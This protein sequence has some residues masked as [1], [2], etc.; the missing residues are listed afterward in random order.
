M[1]YILSLHDMKSRNRDFQGTRTYSDSDMKILVLHA[2]PCLPR[3][4]HQQRKQGPRVKTALRPPPWRKINFPPFFREKGRKIDFPPSDYLD[5]PQPPLKKI[6]PQNILGPHFFALHHDWHHNPTV[7]P[8]C[9]LLHCSAKL[10]PQHGQCQK[11]VFK[12]FKV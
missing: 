8:N 11:I 6:D 2:C 1:I 7:V 4:N 12:V 5:P 3:A 9:P 10:S